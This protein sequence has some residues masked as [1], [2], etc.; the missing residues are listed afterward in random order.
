[1]VLH[2]FRSWTS[3][4]NPVSLTKPLA[5]AGGF[6]YLIHTCGPD[7]FVSSA[8]DVIHWQQPI[9]GESCTLCS[10]STCKAGRE[11]RE[12]HLSDTNGLLLARFLCME[13]S[14]RDF[15]GVFIPANLYLNEDLSWTEK[16]LL[17]EIYYLDH[18][19]G[20]YAGN[21]HLAKFVHKSKQ[22]C[23][24]ILTG[25]RKNGYIVDIRFDGR[26]R[27]I[28][29]T[30]KAGFSRKGY[31]KH[32]ET[33]QGTG[34]PVVSLRE[35]P[36]IVINTSNINTSDDPASVENPREPRPTSRR[37]SFSK[38]TTPLGERS[39]VRGVTRSV[40]GQDTLGEDFKLVPCD[41]DGN[42]TSPKVRRG[43]PPDSQQAKYE[44][45][46][47]GVEEDYGKR[48]VAR[49]KQYAAI[50]KLKAAG[51]TA[52]DIYE[53]LDSVTRKPYYKEHGW[54]MWTVVYEADKR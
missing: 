20:C 5:F 44:E 26:R 15:K 38:K 35:N 16:I 51:L 4:N 54:D 27:W 37:T 10:L 7:A 46:L 31:E 40:G 43:P 1:M 39:E 23:V 11:Q 41:E 12:G 53:I 30:D 24:D 18:G 45:F 2:R 8:R 52:E 49:P 28:G 13:P 33:P 29:V 34:K 22:Q 14:T 50:K 36:Y 19:E 21:E 9:G 3:R 17:T 47:K 48:F 42:T 25:L 6:C 32:D